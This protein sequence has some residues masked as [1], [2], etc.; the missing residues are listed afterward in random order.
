MLVKMKISSASK[1]LTISDEHSASSYGI[2]MAV[3]DGVA[4]GP[5]EFLP[6]WAVDDE[7]N[8]LNEP[9]KTTVAAACLEMQKE[10]C[11]NDEQ[12]AFLRKFYDEPWR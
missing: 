9:A 6:I 12:I 11:I 8:W 4:Y 3:V 2:P 7:L 5:E 10:G 1:T